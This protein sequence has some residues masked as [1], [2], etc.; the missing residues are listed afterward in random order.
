MSDRDA[1]YEALMA[2]DVTHARNELDLSL[3][4]GLIE[5]LLEKQLGSGHGP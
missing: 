4:E 5:S 2:A 1:Y 3:M